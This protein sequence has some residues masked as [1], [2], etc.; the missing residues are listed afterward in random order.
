MFKNFTNE[1]QELLLDNMNIVITTSLNFYGHEKAIIDFCKAVTEYG[2]DEVTEG[3]DS[4][5][6]Q[7]CYKDFLYNAIEKAITD[8]GIIR[9]GYNVEIKI[10]DI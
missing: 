2:F 5:D 8:R 1:L 9:D 10:K 4:V 3:S 7:E 6:I